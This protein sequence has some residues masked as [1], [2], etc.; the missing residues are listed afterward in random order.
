MTYYS[1]HNH[2]FSPFRNIHSGRTGILF[3]TGPSLKEFKLEKPEFKD[4]IKV[5]V[6]KLYHHKEIL[7]ELDYYFFGSH[8][9]L[10]GSHKNNIDHIK[11]NFNNIT[12]F[13]STFTGK[14]GDGRETGM[15][16]INEI[17]ASSLGCLPFEIG[18]PG[19]GP[20]TDWVKDIDK[21]PFYGCSIAF[22]AIQFMLFSGINK[23]YLV[24]CDLGNINLHFHNSSNSGQS[25]SGAATAYLQA[26]K[27]L[28]AFLEKEY[29]LVEIISVNPAGLKGLF[30][31]LYV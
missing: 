13:S 19:H 27:K 29:P 9:H 14:F 18:T 10:D 21:Y 22:P 16:N 25:Q 5:G 6:N 8:Y 4:T 24:G 20:G 1:K 26:W 31:D 28:P 11:E 23:I 15:G 12:F 17:S 30:G 7:G 3:C 2:I